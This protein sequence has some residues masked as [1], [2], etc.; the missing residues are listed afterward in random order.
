[1]Q[2][3]LNASELALVLGGISGVKQPT[4]KTGGSKQISKPLSP[5]ESQGPSPVATPLPQLQP[6]QPPPQIVAQQIGHP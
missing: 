6:A 4:E 1:M 2:I 5:V 3:E